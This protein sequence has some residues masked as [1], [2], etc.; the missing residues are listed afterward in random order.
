[1]SGMVG[2]GGKVGVSVGVAVGVGVGSAPQV[3]STAPLSKTSQFSDESGRPSAARIPSQTWQ[4]IT[5]ATQSVNPASAV[6]A[7]APGNADSTGLTPLAMHR[8]STAPAGFVRRD[9]T[10][11]FRSGAGPP[12]RPLH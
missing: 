7:H 8:S 3:P 1:M 4:A 10:R 5:D 12:G 2:V 9:Q 6:P 11:H